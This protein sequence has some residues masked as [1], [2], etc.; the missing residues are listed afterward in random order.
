MRKVGLVVLVGL[1]LGSLV[2]WQ[3]REHDL[4]WMI[5]AGEEI[6][7]THRV[8]TVDT[9]SY[10]IYGKTWINYQWLAMVIFKIVYTI[11]QT[12]ALIVLRVFLAALLFAL[13]GLI[14]WRA[15]GSS[16]EPISGWTWQRWPRWLSAYLL[17]APALYVAVVFRLQM[18]PDLFG[19]VIFSVLI[20]I[21]VSPW[22]ENR[23]I[24]CSAL[25]LLLWTNIHSGTA[26]FGA[27]VAGSFALAAVR[28]FKKT[29][30]CLGLFVLTFFATP[31]TYRVVEVLLTFFL[32]YEGYNPDFQPLTLKLFDVGKFG[33]A[34]TLWLF[35]TLAAWRRIFYCRRKRIPLP[36]VYSNFWVASGLG[37]LLTAMCVKH[38]RVFPYA[39]IFF[40]PV[41]AT[42]SDE[43]LKKPSAPKF[44]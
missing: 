36:A 16:P 22:T 27:V 43:W 17:L 12:D 7:Q 20:S 19:Y 37:A 2:S 35:L 21:W 42:A 3:V 5:R 8:Q 34:A 30:A 1:G 44:L 41:L 32:H 26:V 11:G 29:L 6:L 23:K 39:L 24:F 10:T 25:G 9:W 33:W 18:R 40:M 14:I 13:Q 31:Q 38:I 28:P 15:L 4:F